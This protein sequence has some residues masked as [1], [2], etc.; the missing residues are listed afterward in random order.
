MFCCGHLRAQDHTDTVHFD[1][2]KAVLTTDGMATLR[3]L[4]SVT[5]AWA[6]TEITIYGHTDTVG[7]PAYNLLLAA[8]R[9]G[10]VSLYLQ[11]AGIRK[12]NIT[13][14]S[15]GE[16]APVSDTNDALNRRVVIRYRQ[17]T[18]EHARP[19][20]TLTIRNTAKE[21]IT[22]QVTFLTQ[23]TQQMRLFR[24]ADSSLGITRGQAYFIKIDADG[25]RSLELTLQTDT[26]KEVQHY[27]RDIVL[28][29]MDIKEILTF[30]KIYFYPNVAEFVKTT[31]TDLEK[32]LL[33]M[34]ED[35]SR[36][37]EIH[38]HINYPVQMGARPPA[39]YQ[40]HYKLSLDRAKAVYRYLVKN[41]IAPQRMT[42]KGLNNS[43]MVVPNAINV[44]DAMK[45]MRVEILLLK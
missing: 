3:H 8:K 25:Y 34:Q 37:I 17:I 14:H 11:K 19:D 28:E 15:L 23:A 42:Y 16:T 22:A 44:E 13:V 18:K 39:L 27:R 41:G 20:L 5:T 33:F 6:G 30:N 29:K 12:L 1:F 10:N 4:V 24:F 40:Q 38:G 21:K 35:T 9:A 7:N 31:S 43:K 2:D 45:N 26:T 32:L 36:V